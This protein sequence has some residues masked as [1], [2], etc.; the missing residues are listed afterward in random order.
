MNKSRN[1][2]HA[3]N[4]F[5]DFFGF[6]PTKSH[7]RISPKMRFSGNLP[8]I[9]K[10]PKYIKSSEMVV[11]GWYMAHFHRRDFLKSKKIGLGGFRNMPD[12]QR[13]ICEF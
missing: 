11:R 1:K 2:I 8:E 12:P 4:Y 3:K 10:F 6:F 9:V 5:L 13:S 7:S